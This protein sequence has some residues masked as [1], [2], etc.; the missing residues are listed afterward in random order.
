MRVTFKRLNH[1]YESNLFSY[2]NATGMLSRIKHYNNR[3]H[4]PISIFN[5]SNSH[6]NNNNKKEREKT[7]IFFKDIF[8]NNYYSKNTEIIRKYCTK[9][10]TE[11]EKE[12][13]DG[14]ISYL[15]HNNYYNQNDFSEI[16]PNQRV[17]LRR[18]ILYIILNLAIL[19]YYI[20]K[21]NNERKVIDRILNHSNSTIIYIVDEK[22]E[23]FNNH[24]Q[25]NVVSQISSLSEVNFQQE[26]KEKPIIDKKNYERSDN[27]EVYLYTANNRRFLRKLKVNNKELS[28]LIF[29]S[30]DNSNIPF[31]IISSNK[32][33]LKYNYNNESLMIFLS[34]LILIMMKP[35]FYAKNGDFKINYRLIQYFLLTFKKHKNRV[36][37]Y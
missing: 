11:K 4:R 5:M 23:E 30:I 13:F 29:D 25:I 18:S 36:V 20:N 12:I 28:D 21:S 6:I 24:N 15:I 3:M 10:L 22:H 2:A 8:P 19:Y 1:N 9:D 26:N 34:L 27:Y 14:H 17:I 7:E 33:L 31:K 35:Y 32:C 16:Y 37:F